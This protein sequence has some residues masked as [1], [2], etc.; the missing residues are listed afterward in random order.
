MSYNLIAQH[1][2]LA[3]AGVDTI[4][5]R[6]MKNQPRHYLKVGYQTINEKQ[7]FHRM[8]QEGDFPL[9]APVNEASPI[10]PVNFWTGYSKDYYWVKY[11][12]G[13][14]TSDEALSTD[15]YGVT[16]R[17]AQKMAQAMEDTKDSLS[18]GLFNNHTSTA[19]AYVGPDGVAMVSTGHPYNGG[20][21][22]NRGVTSSNT[23]VDL[24]ITTLEQMIQAAMYNPK[25]R[26]GN[27][28][29]CM[30]K[31]NLF[32]HPDNLGLA[33]RL[34]TTIQG[35]P[36]TNDNDINWAG[37]QIKACYANPWFT[38][39]DA[40]WLVATD[41]QDNPFRKIVHGGAFSE[42]ERFAQTQEWAFYRTEKFLFHYF[43]ARG[44]HGT[45][46]G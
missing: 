3:R 31:F 17:A 26:E 15:R 32:V 24:G 14:R 23:D 44:I 43:D 16:D 25:S 12:L 28:A 42:K 1:A 35:Q 29:S 33:K 4:H 8:E 11:G 27:P 21:W 37:G 46:G 9:A 13:W 19:A 6:Y 22:S 30:G 38:D 36:Q 10:T 41:T 7:Q 2:E 20:T 34:V 39:A 40:F 45:V 18:A 5:P